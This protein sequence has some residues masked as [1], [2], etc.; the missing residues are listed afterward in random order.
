MTAAND[1]LERRRRA[2][3]RLRAR[4]N[5]LAPATRGEVS[6]CSVAVNANAL[7]LPP[8]TLHHL[9]CSPPPVRPLHP[10][11]PLSRL[12]PTHLTRS[13]PRQK[14]LIPPTAASYASQTFAAD[15][16]PSTTWLAR[17][18]PAPSFI[19]AILGSLVRRRPVFASLTRHTDHN[20]FIAVHLIFCRGDES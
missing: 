1:P 10:P 9:K 16:P 18:M 19:L 5:G 15:C 3:R 4:G 11:D 13:I 8:L 2:C 6:E 12:I 17:R 14:S 7:L 20:A